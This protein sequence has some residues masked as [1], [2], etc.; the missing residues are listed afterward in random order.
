[1]ALTIIAGPCVIEQDGAWLSDIALTLQDIWADYAPE[2]S[3]LV[4]KSSWAKANRSTLSGFRGIGLWDGLQS[5]Y[6]AKEETGLSTLT[7]VH[8]VKHVETCAAYVDVIQIPAF[9]A[10]QTDLVV[11]AAQTGKRVAIKIPPWAGVAEATAIRYKYDNAVDLP[12]EPWMIYRGTAIPD[13]GAPFN[14]DIFDDMKET[15][16]LRP[17]FLDVTHSNGG[18]TYSSVSLALQ[19]APYVQGLFMEVHPNPRKALCDSKHQLDYEQFKTIMML[20]KYQDDLRTS[21]A[22]FGPHK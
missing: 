9:L 16:A 5:L 14:Q 10:R 22:E 11:A 2:G 1:M 12:R 6:R 21:S 19:A 18:D 8:R 3:S 4:I 7:D 13:C 15:E 17:F 20:L